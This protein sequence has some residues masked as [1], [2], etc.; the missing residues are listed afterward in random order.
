MTLSAG[1]L[2]NATLKWTT[3]GLAPGDH[4]YELSVAAGPEDNDALPSNNQLSGTLT[5]TAPEPRADLRVREIILP[6]Q[7][8]RT[9]DSLSVSAVI[10]NAGGLDAGASTLMATLQNPAGMVL[11]FTETEVAVPAVPAGGAVAVNLTGDTSRF[12]AGN[13]TLEVAADYANEVSESNEGNNRLSRALS[14]LEP[15]ARR[16]VLSVG[17]I[18]FAGKR[19]EGEKVDVISSIANSGDGTALGVVVRFFV[20]GKAAATINLDQVEAGSSRNATMTWRF[21]SG[22]H[23]VR[24]QVSSTGLLD[25]S[26]ERK[27][28]IAAEPSDQGWLVPV[29]AMAVVLVLLGV[30]VALRL[31]RPPAPGPKVRLIKEEE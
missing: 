8:P 4:S 1:G 5:L 29:L 27:V 23:T 18:F 28:S 24:V 16:P 20:D 31:R 15:A 17:W 11:R 3:A 10:E 2:M 21:P 12:S 30:A 22:D 19:E 7:P 13:Y 26:G 9:G 14:I 25:V 6:A